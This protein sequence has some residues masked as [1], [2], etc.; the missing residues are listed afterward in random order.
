M[1]IADNEKPIFVYSRGPSFIDSLSSTKYQFELFRTPAG[2]LCYREGHPPAADDRALAE[3]EQELPEVY[4]KLMSWT[5]SAIS[6]PV[7]ED[8]VPQVLRLLHIMRA[9]RNKHAG[10]MV[11]DGAMYSVTVNLPERQ[12]SCT[13]FQGEVPDYSPD[14]T[15]RQIIETVNGHGPYWCND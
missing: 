4:A 12:F 8:K 15:S 13:W 2:G 9:S 6:K 3:I 7:P 14:S 5:D 1:T 10:E 11:L